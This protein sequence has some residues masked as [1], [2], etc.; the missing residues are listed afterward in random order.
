MSTPLDRAFLASDAFDRWTE[1]VGKATDSIT[2]LAPRLDATLSKVL[3]H[4]RIDKQSITVLTTLHPDAGFHSYEAHLD[5]ILHLVTE[6]VEV[7]ATSRPLEAT[8]LIRDWCH[9]TIGSQQFT[10]ESRFADNVSLFPANDISESDF[11]AALV[12][13]LEESTVIRP[14]LITTLLKRLDLATREVNAAHQRLVDEFDEVVHDM[15]AVAPW[16][17]WSGLEEEVP[18]E[19]LGG[20]AFDAHSPAPPSF[21]PIS[22]GLGRTLTDQDLT[23]RKYVYARLRWVDGGYDSLL[24]DDRESDLTDWALPTGD[25][26]FTK[27]ALTRLYIYPIVL[28]PSGRMAFARV[29][30][31]RI[32]YLRQSVAW[33]KGFLIGGR[34]YDVT[35]SF[36]TENFELANLHLKLRPSSAQ[37]SGLQLGIRFDGTQGVLTSSTLLQD[38]D[39]DELSSYR[40]ASLQETQQTLEGEPSALYELLQDALSPFKFKTLDRDNHSAAGFF[41]RTQVHLTLFRFGQRWVLAA[42]DTGRHPIH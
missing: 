20:K 27:V 40:H 31:G 41:P 6:G 17:G 5:G 33:T 3:E 14:E 9:V 13:W 8:T 25:G 16:P 26:D 4:A 10:T 37:T 39:Q 7:R 28:N 21:P 18:G 35:V 24:V 23:A 2:V 34:P 1:F 36:P 12:A 11:K 22:T 32:T 15:E 19:D 30:R 29:A 38:G 42:T